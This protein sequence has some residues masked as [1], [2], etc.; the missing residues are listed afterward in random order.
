MIGQAVVFL[1]ETAFGFFTGVLL[2]RFWVQCARAPHRNPL[3]DFVQTLTNFAVA[4]ARRFIPG[5]W[6]L[7]LSTLFLAWVAQMLQLF[8]VLELRGWSPGADLGTTVLGFALMGFV[9]T[10][11]LALY[12]IIAVLIIQAVISW[13]NP[14]G[15]F[16]PLFNALAR[17]LAR[18][19]QRW[20]PPIGNIDLSPLFVL[21]ACQL[22]LMVPVTWLGIMANR[23]L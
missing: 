3:S 19:F 21:I 13:V 9:M 4:P 18:P 20:I 2:L 17:P 7:D 16:A 14:Y 11:K 1:V 5:L 22:L 6:G 15:P 8:I 10:L 23:L 12:L